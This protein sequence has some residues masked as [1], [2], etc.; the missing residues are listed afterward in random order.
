LESL[1]KSALASVLTGDFAALEGFKTVQSAVLTELGTRTQ[2]LAPSLQ[3]WE[4]LDAESRQ[5]LRVGRLAE[6]LA[7]MEVI[8]QT[9]Q[10]RHSDQFEGEKGSTDQASSNA[11][12]G[13]LAS[14][15]HQYRQLS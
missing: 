6:L 13:D 3:A 9:I 11:S 4:G 12:D 2:A 10:Q 5:S 14:R 8:A 1:Q 7:E 15:I